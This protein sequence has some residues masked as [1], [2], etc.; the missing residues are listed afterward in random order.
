MLCNIIW[1]T[2]DNR[3]G[4]FSKLTFKIH[5]KLPNTVLHNQYKIIVH[6]IEI[7]NLGESQNTQSVT[8]NSVAPHVPDTTFDIP[9]DDDEDLCEGS[10]T[11]GGP[12]LS[13]SNSE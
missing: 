8:S 2:L 11:E 9:C 12:A 1:L 6:N 5:M 13:H 3:T 7:R 10:G 4:K